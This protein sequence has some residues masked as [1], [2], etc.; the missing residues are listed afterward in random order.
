MSVETR[1]QQA[2][3]FLEQD[4]LHLAANIYEDLLKEHPENIDAL[5]GSA[6]ICLQT[7]LRHEARSFCA[8]VLEL[9]PELSEAWTL[10]ALGFEEEDLEKA[11]EYA[12]QAVELEANAFSLF[13]AARLGGQVGL[14]EESLQWAL[15][16]RDLAPSDVDAWMLVGRLFR[17]VGA[18]REAL[19]VWQHI[20]REAP[21]TLTAYLE[22]A[23]LLVEQSEVE[24]AL[25]T[26]TEARRCCGSNAL[27][28][29]RES[30]L[31]ALLGQW[32]R[33]AEL[34]ETV[35]KRFPDSAEAWVNVGLFR[36]MEKEPEAAEEAFRQSLQLNAEQWEAP[37]YL[38]ELTNAAGL[39]EQAERW[40]R[41]ALTAAPE[42]WASWNNL[43]LLLM[44]DE[45]RT[46][47]AAECF[48]KS[49]DSEPTQPEPLLN[50]G[51]A[52]FKNRELKHAAEICTQLEQHP[53]LT[54][55]LRL[56]TT[57]LREEINLAS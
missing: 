13:H 17:S 16:A 46:A 44:T 1:L 5:L 4:K 38:G 9:E 19:E 28:E 53:L 57:H 56:A 27:L 31:Q 52:Y 10:L 42:H 32:G 20:L 15:Q 23:E 36:L 18:V 29:L 45:A 40:Y 11:L 12:E 6:R 33:A 21:R 54:D 22:L 43:G 7:D 35:R 14:F 39:S 34:A 3:S 24:L 8:E 26:L 41:K 48:A 2:R 50:L 51:L 49:L 25:E 47:E 30:H 37:F 55:E